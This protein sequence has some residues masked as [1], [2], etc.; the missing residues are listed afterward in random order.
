MISK[1][2]KQNVKS[3]IYMVQRKKIIRKLDVVPALRT[4]GAA[5]IP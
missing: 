4:C 1:S 5:S 3:D 2:G